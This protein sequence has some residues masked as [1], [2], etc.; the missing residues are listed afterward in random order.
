LVPFVKKVGEEVAEKTGEAIFNL[1]QDKLKG[2]KEAEGI[3]ENFGKKPDRYS[4]A[5]ADILRE[6]AETDPEFGAALE[7]LLQ[8]AE[9]EAADRVTQIAQGTGIAQ[10]AGSGAS[11]TV[12]M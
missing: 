7:K 11:A 3:L 4:V 8:H 12:S 6:Q 10:A 5:L 1:V 2:D 9:E